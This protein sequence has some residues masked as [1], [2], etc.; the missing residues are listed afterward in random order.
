MRADPRQQRRFAVPHPARWEGA[1]RACLT[2]PSLGL[3]EA[4]ALDGATGLLGKAGSTVCLRGGARQGGAR[5]LA[6]RR[7]PP[8]SAPPLFIAPP[9]T[10]LQSFHPL[11]SGLHP[12]CSRVWWLQ[13]WPRYMDKLVFKGLGAF[14][15][16][17]KPAVTDSLPAPQTATQ[18]GRS[19]S[20][21]GSAFSPAVLAA[22]L[23]W[24]AP[25]PLIADSGTEENRHRALGGR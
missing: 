1:R 22:R 14:V 18:V 5:A 3:S 13:S 7:R 16:T 12:S 19:K 11:F 2:L 4:G 15:G 24:R 21:R 10:A 23:T 25:L 6:R 17:S 8:T 9:P 20:F